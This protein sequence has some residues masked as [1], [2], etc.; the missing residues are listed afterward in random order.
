MLVMAASVSAAS[1]D[2]ADGPT[3]THAFSPGHFAL[4]ANGA[5]AIGNA[6]GSPLVRYGANG[7]V[8]GVFD[9]GY[10]DAMMVETIDGGVALM[11]AIAPY[12]TPECLVRK[13]ASNGAL[14]WALDVT[15]VVNG[16]NFAVVCDS[17]TADAVGTLWLTARL[18]AMDDPVFVYRVGSDGAGYAGPLALPANFVALALAASKTAG[19]YVAGYDSAASHPSVVALDSNGAVRWQFTDT[20]GTGTFTQVAVDSTGNVHVAGAAADHTSVVAVIDS[21]GQAIGVTRLSAAGA[22]RS[23]AIAIASDGSMFVYAP[24]TDGTHRV[25]QKFDPTALPIGQA[26]VPVQGVGSLTSQIDGHA[27]LRIAANGDVVV[28]DDTGH[29]AT[30]SATLTVVRFDS[31]GNVKATTDIDA[32][33]GAAAIYASSLG[34]LADSSALVSVYSAAAPSPALLLLPQSGQFVQVDTAGHIGSSAL[35]TANALPDSNT[36]VASS[37]ADDGSTYLLTNDVG[38]PL[39]PTSIALFA[40]TAVL[41]AIAPDGALAW[42]VEQDGFWQAAA[43]AVDNDRVC[44]FGEFAPHASYVFGTDLI[45]ADEEPDTRVECHDRATGAVTS[46][47]T[48]APPDASLALI[49]GLR[50]AA[51]GTLVAAY[52]TLNSSSGIY[53]EVEIATLDASGQPLATTSIDT[54]V[55]LFEGCADG[56]YAIVSNDDNSTITRV[57]PDGA[58]EWTASAPGTSAYIAQC[59]PDGSIALEGVIDPSGLAV[60]VTLMGANGTPRWTTSIASGVASPTIAFENATSDG[61]NLYVSAIQGLDGI[62]GGYPVESTVTRL[63][64]ADGRIE[65]SDTFKVASQ[66]GVAIDPNGNVPVEYAIE[67]SHVTVRVLDPAT[68]AVRSTSA[69]ACNATL[70]DYVRRIETARIG[71]DDT[72]RYVLS[73]GVPNVVGVGGIGSTPASIDITQ[74]SLSGIWYAPYESGQGFGIDIA[75]GGSIFSSWFTDEPGDLESEFLKVGNDPATLNWYTLQGDASDANDSATLVIY[76]NTGGAFATGSTSAVPVGSATLRFGDCDH[77]E[78]DYQFDDDGSPAAGLSGTIDLVRLTQQ[79]GDCSNGSSSDA[80]TAPATNAGFDTNQSG[81]WYDPS[82]SGQGLEL[83][84]LPASGTSAGLLFG[85]WFT[86]DPANASDDSTNQHW[87]TLQADFASASN[88]AVVVPIYST[89]GGTFDNRPGTTT[90]RVGQGTLTFDGC[91]SGTF[92]YQFDG[93]VM[94]GPYRGLSG[95]LNLVPLTACQH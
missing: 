50:F 84:V 76:A 21:T 4:D 17:L 20:T 5:W 30:T 28:L 46:T 47:A 57:G 69:Q 88:G 18:D 92:S 62:V 95:T 67:G 52:A 14:Q 68:G 54:D 36:H 60:G 49:G 6:P 77:G 73:G 38:A 86:Y 45:D 43:L 53:D 29:G 61:T 42:K 40:S 51:D 22:D 3:G 37:I 93:T 64:L 32:V 91:S 90:I 82:A 31:G 70:C 33:D 80:G 9:D 87:F 26:D 75:P 10:V 74:T 89:L 83:S 58:V 25:L 41:A 7:A 56:G 23:S 65:W 35:M 15:D 66:N 79:V 72:L 11:T 63:A 16:S 13:H 55:S 24:S 71:E 94:A 85:A 44:I 59:L 8:T 81:A 1:F 48:L 2:F 12:G 27:G 78:L 39:D 19:S 34:T